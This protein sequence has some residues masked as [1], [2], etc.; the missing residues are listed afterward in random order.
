MPGDSS[1][2]ENENEAVAEGFR[3]NVALILEREDGNIFL[4]ERIDR[5]D[6]WQF[7]Q[8]GVDDG[9]NYAGALC[10]EVE[11]EIGI[12][13]QAYE[14]IERRG[15]YRYMF[16]KWHRRNGPYKGQEQTYFRCRF[17]GND[18]D[19]DLNT[20]KPEFSSY[21]WIAPEDFNI[22]WLPDFKREVYLRVLSDFFGVSLK[23]S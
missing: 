5:H 16:P 4:G 19:I 13:P 15:G 9:E 18:G 2:N 17:L 22:N 6:A 23:S 11:E 3:R 10:R 12:L 8:G 21:Q 20:A 7:P 14:I 1:S